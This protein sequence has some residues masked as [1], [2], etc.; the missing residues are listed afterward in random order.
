MTLNSF[1]NYKFSDGTFK[2]DFYDK[3][4][5]ENGKQSGK[6]WLENYHFIPRRNF[7]EAFAFI[8]YLELDDD[9]YVLDLGGAK[10]FIVK[11]L[12]MLDIRADV[13]D[14][15][16][17]ALQFA[18]EGSWNCSTEESWKKHE[19]QYTHVIIKDMLEHLTEHQL[20]DM[21]DKISL[22]SPI[23]M[24]VV[25]MGD[26]GTYRIPEYHTEVS[27]IIAENEAWWRYRFYN[28]GWKIIK[29]TP[30]VK[31]LKENWEHVHNGNHVFAL[32]KK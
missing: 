23:F 27:H 29:D 17:Y 20:Y 15:S 32:E 30:H 19:N 1:K 2:P 9:S 18:P 12:R 14:I 8:D 26:Q 13:A 21:L 7:R 22:V 16:S 3:D 11:A 28:A 5:Y 25:P 10:G 24:T 4:Y 31:G 6:G